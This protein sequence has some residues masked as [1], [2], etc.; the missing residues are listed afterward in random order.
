MAWFFY[1]TTGELINLDHVA[2]ITRSVRII[3]GTNPVT[4]DQYKG[5][6]YS[7]D[8]AYAAGQTKRYDYATE[9]DR[10]IVFDAMKE[11]A[12]PP[13][14]GPGRPRKETTQQAE[15]TNESED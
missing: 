7:I 3:E 5:P 4:L 15:T 8:I 11:A 12:I 6:I 1:D 9:E 10:D 2:K 14:R 13:V